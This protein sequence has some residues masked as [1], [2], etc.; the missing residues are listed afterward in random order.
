MTLSEFVTDNDVKNGSCVRVLG[1]VT[2]WSVTSLMWT[3]EWHGKTAQVD[4][5][6]VSWTGAAGT[7]EEA[8]LSSNRLLGSL[9][10]VIGEARIDPDGRKIEA[11]VVIDAERSV[12]YTSG[13][14]S[15]GGP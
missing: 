3:M 8:S 10:F 15:R 11:R 12:E 1:R 14:L 9:I 6:K 7:G 5:S 4:A 13:N 2:S